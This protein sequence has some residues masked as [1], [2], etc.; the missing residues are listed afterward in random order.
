MA[1][2]PPMSTH[3]PRKSRASKPAGR[4]RRSSGVGVTV[5]EESC[6]AAM[7]PPEP[8]RATPKRATPKRAA[9]KRSAKKFAKKSTTASPQQ[10]PLQTVT[11]GEVLE[12]L[13][14]AAAAASAPAV[15]EAKA[16]KKK[17]KRQSQKAA[18][19]VQQQ[20]GGQL[21]AAASLPVPPLE[22]EP[23][24]TTAAAASAPAAAAEPA[25]LVKLRRKLERAQAHLA[26]CDATKRKQVTASVAALQQKLAVAEGR[27]TAAA[28]E[29]PRR[30]AAL[31]LETPTPPPRQPAR[32]APQ[33]AQSIGWMT[34]SSTTRSDRAARFENT[35]TGGSRWLWHGDVEASPTGKG[36]SGGPSSV[37]G[38]C[39]T[40]EKEYAR[41]PAG[42]VPDPANIRPAKVLRAALKLVLQ[43]WKDRPP[44]ER[45]EALRA[46]KLAAAAS[47]ATSP[48]AADKD[49]SPTYAWVTSQLRA[50]RQDL[51]VQNLRGVVARRCYAAAVRCAL[52]ASDWAEFSPSLSRLFELYGEDDRNY[53]ITPPRHLEVHGYL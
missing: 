18:K 3:T 12:P 32:L 13:P 37:V 6:A 23:E 4:R 34:E 49:A 41:V 25:K 40:L 31:D 42:M 16:L 50:I 39:T 38:T 14:A 35:P 17:L 28:A 27:R 44:A 5:T 8:E 11:S 2:G 9:P 15:A 30:P 53:A 46:A 19:A 22:P 52:D 33:Q 20:E 47:P 51:T 43:R 36:A 7:P 21:K 45:G 26:G 10:E 1:A 29:I 48:T 24:R